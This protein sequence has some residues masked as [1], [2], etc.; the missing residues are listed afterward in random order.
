MCSHLS[1]HKG[2]SLPEVSITSF[3]PLQ[4]FVFVRLLRVQFSDQ[5]KNVGKTSVLYIFK[6]V[7][8]LTKEVRTE[9][10]LKIYKTHT[11]THTQNY[12]TNYHTPCS[13]CRF[14]HVRPLLLPLTHITRIFHY[15]CT[16]TNKCTIIPQF[17][18]IISEI[19]VH[20]S[21]TVQNVLQY[22]HFC[23][24]HPVDCG[25]QVSVTISL[26]FLLL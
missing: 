16:T 9:T 17:I 15:F 19:I 7:S 23:F 21:A 4:F 14:L 12:F 18:V 25:V 26:S 1:C 5:Y 22:F 24:T 13:C 6:I 3:L 10:I 11:H 2:C 8:V 20:P